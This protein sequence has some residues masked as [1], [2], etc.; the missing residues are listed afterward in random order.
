MAQTF[1]ELETG[2]TTF[3]ELYGI[4]NNNMEAL[5]SCFSGTTFPANPTTPQLCIR[6]DESPWRIYLHTGGNVWEDIT[7]YMPDFQDIV[8]E[9]ELA[10]GE[11]ASLNTRLTVSINPD[12]TLKGSAPVG[13][14][15]ATEADTVAY[16]SSNSFTVN[17]DKTAIYLE[18]RAVYLTQTSNAYTHVSD[19]TY[20]GGSGQTI[21]TTVDAVVDSGL[22]AV[23]YGQPPNNAT[24]N[25]DKADKVTGATAGNL[26]GLDANGNLTDS[27][28]KVGTGTTDLVQAANIPSVLAGGNLRDIQVFESSGTYTRPSW[29]KF[30]VVK[31]WGGGGAGGGALTCAAGI[32]S[33]GTGGGEGGC[34]FKKIATSALGA[35]ETVTIGNGGVGVSGSGGG[36][37]GTTSFGSHCSAT[38]G[39]GGGTQSLGSTYIGG[40]SEGGVG[41]GGTLNRYGFKGQGFRIVDGSSLRVLGGHGGGRGG[42]YGALRPLAA[43]KTDGNN[44]IGFA[45]GGG[46]GAGFENNTTA[47]GGNGKPGICLIYEYE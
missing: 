22:S 19:A 45:G 46:G 16:A 13:D 17:G 18:K 36:N 23:E 12:G 11:A 33:A 28:Q 3:G 42:G 8:D 37:G 29:L 21:V 2:V 26:A 24:Y 20:D 14:W 6:T 35:T 31:G 32:G 40:G 5:Q 41:S 43:G 10:R 30:V 39:S 44:A 9:V 34:F 7:D 4:L 1:N 25:D 47:A 38:G 27:A 15:W